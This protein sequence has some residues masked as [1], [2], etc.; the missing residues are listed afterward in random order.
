MGPTKDHF[1]YFRVSLPR[2][3]K[4]FREYLR[5]NKNIFKNILGYCS[6]AQVLSIH[7]K[8]Q[9]SKI[10]CY[11]PFKF[12]SDT[13]VYCMFCMWISKA[14]V[15]KSVCT[16]YTYVCTTYVEN[17]DKSAVLLGIGTGIHILYYIYCVQHSILYMYEC[18]H[19][20]VRVNGLL[21]PLT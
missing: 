17:A 20:T 2:S 9:S 11:S 10:S 12:K 13:L 16:V 3:Q 19:T 1:C 14:W 8:K 5:E 21:V 7:A 6:R 15:N 18:V 4:Y